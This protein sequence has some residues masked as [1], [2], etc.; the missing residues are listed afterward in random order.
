[1]KIDDPRVKITPDYPKFKLQQSIGALSKL[2]LG[3]GEKL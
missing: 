3:V 1:M 2:D